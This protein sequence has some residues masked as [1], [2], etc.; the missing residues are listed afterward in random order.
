MDSKILCVICIIFFL[1]SGPAELLPVE[2]PNTYET[3]STG[4]LEATNDVIRINGDEDLAEKAHYGD[5][6]EE[7]PF[8]ISDLTIDG[9]D[10]GICIFIGNTTLHFRIE[11]C[12]LFNASGDSNIY[13][14]NSGIQLYNVTNGRIINNEIRDCGNGIQLN[15]ASSE[16]LISSNRIRNNSDYGIYLYRSPSNLIINNHVHNNTRGIYSLHYSHRTEI[17]NNTVEGNTQNGIYLQL[18]ENVTISENE[19]R[20]NQHTGIYISNSPIC[21]V[22]NNHI[23]FNRMRGIYLYNTR[24]SRLQENNMLDNGISLFGRR[25]ELWNTHHIT[26][27]NL[28]NNSP[29]VYWKDQEGGTVPEGAG[30]VILA[31]CTYVTVEDQNITDTDLG[32]ILGFSSNNTV[33]NNHVEGCM[34]GIYLGDS[35]WNFVG[36]NILR[37]NS[38]G[39][40]TYYADHNVIQGNHLEENEQ[41]ITMLLSEEGHILNNEVV[42]ND[43]GVYLLRTI[44]ISMSYNTMLGHGILLGGND[45]ENWNTHSISDTNTAN[46]KPVIYW[47]N[48]DSGE[49]PQGA[50]QII[51]ANCSGVTV[52]YQE[53]HGDY[54]GIKLGFS[55]SN[56]VIHNSVR[57]CWRG[58]YLFISNENYISYNALGSCG[59]GVHLVR[60][61]GNMIYDNEIYNNTRGISFANSDLNQGEKNY[62]YNNTYGVYLY[63]S[64][65]ISLFNNTM[66]FDGLWIDGNL[67]RHWDTHVI[68]T[69]NTL[70]GR[71]IYYI[72]KQADTVVPLG[73]G[74]IILANCVNVTVKE[75]HIRDTSGGILIGYSEDCQVY[76]NTLM[77]NDRGIY[78]YAST[79]NTIYRNNF[80]KNEVQA[81]SYGSND[82]YDEQEQ[83]GNHWFDYKDKY[84]YA[85]EADSSGIWD[86][87]YEV[88][89]KNNIDRYPAMYP[90]GQLSME[91]L[92]PED[93]SIFNRSNVFV[94]WNSSGGLDRMKHSVRVD[95]GN[96]TR[97]GYSMEYT[98]EGL[99][100]GER[101]LE[102][103]AGDG[104]LNDISQEM[105]IIVDTK[106]P[107]LDIIY[108]KSAEMIKN[109][110]VDIR[111]EGKDEITGISHNEISLGDRH[112]T[113]VGNNTSFR[114]SGLEDGEHTVMVR[115]WDRA[116]NH[117]TRVVNFTVDTRL[118]T[119]DIL[120]PREGMIIGNDTVKVR[121]EGHDPTTGIDRYEIRVAGG[122]WIDTGRDTSHILRG[123]K[124]GT[125]V[126]EVRAWDRAGHNTIAEVVFIVDSEPPSVEI[127]YP[128]E[129]KSFL[130]NV[131]LVEWNG[132][133]ETSGIS[134]YSIR[135]DDDWI[136]VGTSTSYTLIG[137]KEGDHRITVKAHD[138]AGHNS[139]D[140]VSFR[141]N[142]TGVEEEGP[143][144]FILVSV[145][146]ITVAILSGL[147]YLI[148]KS[149]EPRKFTQHRGHRDEK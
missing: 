72:K 135:I 79:D 14:R 49:V 73:A 55:H 20:M 112:W 141:V 48:R 70:N 21:D 68:D 45:I 32:I 146:G 83:I 42:A 34:Q 50:G 31:N 18:S 94:S 86:T 88:H 67:F 87:P 35:P 29:V 64:E 92:T 47:K 114:Y 43:L 121:W 96:W 82:W 38:R 75:Q 122:E 118:P 51:L 36:H 131:I 90:F 119:L 19:I 95:S 40:Y 105:N 142:H 8:V 134:H 74:Q 22:L 16:N 6:T 147:I 30:Q 145:I 13:F 15:S 137:L 124:D 144:L 120:H 113:Y 65:K 89:G 62:L 115:A 138:Y 44:N 85:H 91:I 78:L 149:K 123:I 3:W 27:D 129:G 100:D 126:V 103:R 12:V 10:K 26:M 111:W 58:I 101:K 93:R 39:I 4:T 102:V 108:P 33:I 60:S 104:Y 66:F 98:F 117:I 41:G 71:P 46:G 128:V 76:D 130:S 97:V 81:I 63:Q 84:P 24:D 23:A 148:K 110:T 25:V 69:D 17:I 109:D 9:G 54:A 133:D 11:N 5:G 127:T 2:M 28:I 132:T 107:E 125:H 140:T 139:T 59:Q 52:R 37:G 143:N 116:G 7:D 57:D 80:I 53:I 99:K 1:F 136:H 77:Y 61:E 106:P 56:T